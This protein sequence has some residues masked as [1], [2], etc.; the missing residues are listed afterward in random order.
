LFVALHEKP[1]GRQGN[2]R[3]FA[4]KVRFRTPP[5]ARLS[6]DLNIEGEERTMTAIIDTMTPTLFWISFVAL[7]VVTH[8]A[9]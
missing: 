9:G 1:A 8:L 3:Q 4:R 2:A 5:R 6:Y 7:G